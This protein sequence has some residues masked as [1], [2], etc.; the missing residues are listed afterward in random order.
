[1]SQ[2][3]WLIDWVLTRLRGYPRPA[4]E[5]MRLGPTATSA[6]ALMIQFFTWDCRHPSLTWWQHFEAEVP[7]LAELGVTQVW[8]PPPH[9]AMTERGQGY[10]AYDL[11]DLGEFDQKGT[12]ATRWGTREQLLHAV[13]VARAHGIDV[14]IDAVLNH[15]LGAD[16][17]ETFMA[18][19]VDPQNRLRDLT[20]PREVEGW[21]AF[22]FPGRGDC[23]SALKWTQE[24][25]T[26]LDWDHKKRLK[27][28]YRI[29]GGS[30]K[31]WSK[32]VDNELGNYDYLL[33]ADIDHRHP[34][35]RQDLFAWGEWILKTTG[36]AGFRLDAIKHIDRYFLLDFL[37][38]IRQ[39]TGRHDLFAVAEYWSANIKVLKPYIYAFQGMVAFFD[40]PLH[41]NFH[42]ASKTGPRYDLRTIFYNTLLDFR[43][44]DAITFVDNHECQIGQSLESWVGL[45]FKL[46]AYALILLRGQGHPCVFYGDLYPNDECFDTRVA[47][48]LRVLIEA[49]K[50]YAYGECTDYFHSRNCIGFVRAGDVSHSGCAVL[51][52]N[53]SPTIGAKGAMHSVRMNVGSSNGPSAYTTLFGDER[54]DVAS[55]G[56]G[57]FTCP[58]GRLQ[59]WVK[60]D[61]QS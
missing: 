5:G 47:K 21:T 22:D 54:V 17:T 51:V 33:G 27:G 14:L 31:G 46:Q 6:N 24:H 10:D 11:W 18:V 30:H 19:P 36:G 23:H 38:H 41:D 35:V 28:V 15:K 58:P 37:K 20:P 29:I 44:G 26:G 2:R 50:K 13:E 1:M 48:G 49:R 61:V 25:F 39:T 59:I 32:F 8:L 42:R 43:P 3:N 60:R 52:S 53:T 7:T 56:W 40:V 34:D 4:L 55:D 9:K 57:I 12:V 16:R 45:N